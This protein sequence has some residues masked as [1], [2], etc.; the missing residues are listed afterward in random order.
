MNNKSRPD[1]K[2]RIGNPNSI[3]S[4]EIVVA[5]VRFH[6]NTVMGKKGAKVWGTGEVRLRS[7]LI[8]SRR[9]GMTWGPVNLGCAGT[10]RINL[11][12]LIM[13][14][15]RGNWVGIGLWGR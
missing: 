14:H 10:N 4:D 13:I 6:Q 8:V 9:E 3:N 12:I 5:P 2:I 7:S 15:F 11:G 1:K